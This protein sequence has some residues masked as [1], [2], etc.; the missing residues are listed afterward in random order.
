[1][2][3]TIEQ[4]LQKGVA[5][6]K[7]GKLQDAERLYRAI[8]QSQ[9]SHPDANHNLGVLA[10]SVNKAEAALSL[11]KTALDANPKMG[12]FWLSYIDAL[13]RAEKV[14]DARQALADA[15]Q[16]GVTAAK[17]QIFEEQLEFELSPSSQIPQQEISNPLHSHHGELSAAIELREAGKYKEA[18]ELLSSVIEHDSRNAEALSLLSQ[19]LLLDKKAAAAERVLRVAASI[20]SELPSVYRNQARLLLNQAKTPEALE[21]AQMGCKQSQEDS[22]SLLV[23]AACL[24]ANQRDLEALRLI[25]NIL[26]V[27]SNCAEAYANRA[28]IRL[29]A[30]NITGAIEDAELTV[31]LKPH[32]TQMWQLL[33]SLYYESSNLV[34]AI[35]ALKIAHKNEPMNLALMM[36]LGEFLRQ[37]N[38]TSEAITILEQAKEISPK[39]AKVWINL[40]VAYQQEKRIADA[41]IAYEAALAISPKAGAVLSNLGAMAKE[42]AEFESALHYFERALEAQ[43]NLAEAHN[44][45]GATLQELGR[46]DES[47]ASYRQAITLKPDYAEAHSNLGNV[48]QEL[49][50]LEEA[51]TSYRQTIALTPDNAKA[52][53]YLGNTLRDLGRLDEAVSSRQKAFTLRTGIRPGGREALAP[54]TDA[55]FF[56]L[57]N[58]CNFHCTF[59][60]SDDQKRSLGSMDLELVKQ[61]Y[62]E[63]SHK[64][65]ASVVNLHLMG[66]P[67]LHPELI[68]VL[69]FGASKHI[70]TDLVTNISTLVDKNI[71]K[72]LDAL[73]GTITASHMTPTEETYHFRGEVKLPWDRYVSNLRLLV[74]EYMQRLADGVSRKNEITIRVMVTQDTASNVSVIKTSNDASAILK[75]WND[76]VAEVEQELGMAP[77]ER[78]D[79]NVDDL[80]RGNK[81]SSTS[82]PLQQG[83]KLT[84]WR[85]FT[86]ANTRVS[87][88]FDLKATGR[89]SYCSKPFSDVGVL[90]NGDVT[91][92]G[93]DHDGQLK[94]GNVLDSSI[95]AVIQ[96]D[97]AQKL[98]AAML[99][100][101]PLPSICQ[102]CQERPVKRENS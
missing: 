83:I 5:A 25:E 67:T 33:G 21:K 26:K 36:Q 69:K 55:L 42:A 79:H 11:F 81:H 72:I 46:F 65:L 100:E 61:L 58:K 39:D 29:R 52:H 75:E 57:T 15:Q 101:H 19:V 56:E 22:E 49:G 64:N 13:I 18:Q 7:E 89:T 98:R 4:A 41:K 96:S 43:P 85:A 12:Q 66:E 71:P 60:P 84:F 86:F 28:L 93:L 23:L 24:R 102:K 59:C 6:Y 78:K 74:R 54:A 37:D 47:E 99:G 30:K 40:G 34:D 38:K 31:S 77:F 9:P 73:Y 90:W 10:V 2:E 16:A 32:L 27:N 44:N 14:D 95:E 35:E 76:F 53:S 62:E 68:E 20:N 70:K 17:L 97:A 3:L 91:L 82:Y 48:L 50:R 88:D 94:V 63:A 87:D 45:L 92:C 80:A 8:L 1:M 51:E